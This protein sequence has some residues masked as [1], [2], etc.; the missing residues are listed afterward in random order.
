MLWCYKCWCFKSAKV[1]KLLKANSENLAQ[2][3]DWNTN[4]QRLD[5]SLTAAI[6]P[7]C[8]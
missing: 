8:N 7:E 3:F 4:F 6:R 1:K 5:D 2:D